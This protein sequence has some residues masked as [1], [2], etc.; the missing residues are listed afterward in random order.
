MSDYEKRFG[1]IARLYGHQA[2]ERLRN[3]HVAVVGIGGVGSWT[4]EALARSGVGRLTLIDLDDICITNTNRQVH[5]TGH[6]LGQPKVA[7]MRHRITAIN[8]EL[9]VDVVPE[10]LTRANVETF[11]ETRFD[12]VVDAIDD[13]GNKCLLLAQARVTRTPLVTTGGAGGRCDLTQIRVADLNAVTHDALIRQVRKRL[14]REHGFP[15]DPKRSLGVPC[16]FS[17]EPVRYPWSDGTV[18]A[19]KEPGSESLRLDCSSGYGTATH[20]TGAFGFA[21]AAEAIRL[22]TGSE[23]GN[24]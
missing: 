3:A 10:F 23:R 21:A 6:T 16:V 2:L 17:T 20:L 9:R 13:V 24:D 19:D 18:C 7:A 8:P 4:V 5:S 15:D 14:R 22:V 1:G 12:C 11:F